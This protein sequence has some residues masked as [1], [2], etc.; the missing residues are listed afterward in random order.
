MLE[1][2][3][4]IFIATAQLKPSWFWLIYNVLITNIIT[5]QM[6]PSLQRGGILDPLTPDFFFRVW[7][8]FYSWK[9]GLGSSS[10]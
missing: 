3:L 2:P 9:W 1:K 6:A 7:T 10:G 8:W 4:L 5:L